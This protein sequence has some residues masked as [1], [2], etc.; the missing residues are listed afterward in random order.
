MWYAILEFLNVVGVLTNA[1]LVTFTSSYGRSWEE[2]QVTDE[3]TAVFNSTTNT[4]HYVRTVTETPAAISRLWL[5]IG[6][7][8][9]P[10]LISDLH[11][12]LPHVAM[13]MSMHILLTCSPQR[14]SMNDSKVS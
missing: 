8:V 5:I 12:V 13:H 9:G 10:T 6:F 1:L 11:G 2:A 14:T 3:M 4:T 7:E